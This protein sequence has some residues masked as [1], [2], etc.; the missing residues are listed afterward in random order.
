M[1][2]TNPINSV[3]P[4][5]A[6]VLKKI[7]VYDPR[8]LM[9]ITKLDAIRSITFLSELINKPPKSMIVP[10]IGG[11]AG[12]TIIPLWSKTHRPLQFGVKPPGVYIIYILIILSLNIN[13]LHL[14]N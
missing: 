5:A 14:N 6:E 2:I 11:H 10:V 9:G 12:E 4:L 3:V 13:L 1:I 7:G 8:R